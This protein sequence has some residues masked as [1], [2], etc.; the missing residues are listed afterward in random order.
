MN[1][2]KRRADKRYKRKMAKQFVGFI[3]EILDGLE[4]GEITIKECR[5]QMD[6]MKITLEEVG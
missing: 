6:I 4:S 3:D 2:K 5:E 1:A